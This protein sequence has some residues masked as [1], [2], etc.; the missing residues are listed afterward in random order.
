MKDFIRGSYNK[1]EHDFTER[2]EEQLQTRLVALSQ[3]RE[4]TLGS[5]RAQIEREMT[6]IAFELAERER[7]R[8]ELDIETAWHEYEEV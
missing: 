7:D 4:Y 8:R 1:F 6:N 2:P 5:R 3:S